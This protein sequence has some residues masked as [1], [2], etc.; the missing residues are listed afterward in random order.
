MTEHADITRAPAQAGSR[1]A[2]P[3][4]DS[5]TGLRWWAA[6]GVFIYHMQIFAPVPIIAAVAPFGNHGVAFFF[7]LSGFVLTWS[8]RPSTTVRNFYWRRFARIYPAHFVAL[9]LAIP[10]FYQL[11]PGEPE[12]WWVKPFSLGI[13]LLS[14]PLLQ[15]WFAD[16][17]IVFSGNPAAW[18]LTV[19]FFF[20][21]IHPFVH[22]LLRPLRTRGVTVFLGAVVAA[23]FGFR[24]LVLVGGEG[25]WQHVPLPIERASD[26]LIGMGIALLLKVGVRLRLSPIWGYVLIAG[27][28]LA[29]VLLKKTGALPE[30]LRI[31]DGFG[32][33]IL[34]VLFAA[35]I[36]LVA[37]RDLRGGSS[38]LRRRWMVKLG[39]W[40]F[41]FYLVHATVMYAAA[42]AFGQQPRSFAEL[43]W[44]PVIGGIALLAAWALYRFVEHPLEARMRRW[45]NARFQPIEL[46]S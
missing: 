23:S 32:K 24:A 22:R 17:V 43:V 33:E 29:D 7:V 44:Y 5:L 42:A 2:T 46:R 1:P 6:F 26:F 28:V 10:V 30:L 45:G 27:Y 3:R 18:T 14:I 35:L 8:A 41:A 34:V 37:E 38:F 36:L 11:A 25:W 40:S 12:H 13:L 39:E 31:L 4:L 20:Y 16:P 15:A 9:L 21:A 19:E